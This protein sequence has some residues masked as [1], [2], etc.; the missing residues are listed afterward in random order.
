MLKWLILSGYFNLL[1][2]FYKSGE[3]YKALD[4]TGLGTNEDI[5]L[6]LC[7]LTKVIAIYYT[8]ENHNY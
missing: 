3:F 4:F 8:N 6:F 2:F 1:N 7:P 5:S